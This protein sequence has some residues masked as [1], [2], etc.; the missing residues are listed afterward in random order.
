MESNLNVNL[1]KAQGNAIT[2]FS[3]KL[4]VSQGG[5]AQNILKDPYD[6]SF[7]N[8]QRG[9][10]ERELEDALVN[11]ISRFVLSHRGNHSRT[12]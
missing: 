5:L 9:Y 4:P 12:L 2:N 8:M 1:Y 7:L 6:F 10:D 11:N 3:S